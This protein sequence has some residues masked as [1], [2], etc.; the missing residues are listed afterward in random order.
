MKLIG[1]TGG[2]GMGKSA[3][4]EILR[5]RGVAVVDTDEVSRRLT[6]PGQPALA[7]IQK[8][9]GAQILTADGALNRSELARRV[10]A[11]ETA[12]KKL[13]AILHPRIRERWLAQVAAWRAEQKPV[14]VV[15]IPLLFETGAE[16]QFDRVVCVACS[17]ATQS[18]RLAERGW[19]PTQI[20][21]R[22]AAQWPVQKKMDAAHHVV[23]SEG[24][25]AV[26]AAQLAAIF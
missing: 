15:V 4:A 24:E 22:N 19:T 16:T 11:D 5:A 14:A 26:L 25:L 9:F 12:R 1:L 2:I 8:T 3:A 23:W 18:V 21:A 20:A 10:F 17:P 13:E 6:A 7:E